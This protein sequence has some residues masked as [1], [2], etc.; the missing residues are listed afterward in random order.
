M[1]TKYG[2]SDNIGPIN[3]SGEHD[4]VF[5]GRDYTA[6]RNFSEETGAMIDR[7]IKNIVDEAY[8]RCEDIL[9]SNEGTLHEVA[10]YLLANETMDAEAFERFFDTGLVPGEQDT[11]A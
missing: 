1:V 8:R 10:E 3:Y 6:A 2:M 7:E 9:K 11:E 4:E 5:L